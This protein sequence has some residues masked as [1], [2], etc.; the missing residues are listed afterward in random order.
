MPFKHALYYLPDEEDTFYFLTLIRAL[1]YDHRP[2]NASGNSYGFWGNTVFDDAT[3]V[4]QGRSEKSYFS[5]KDL[6]RD[7]DTVHKSGP[8]L[9]QVLG[10]VINPLYMW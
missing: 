5:I 3:E 9:G 10:Q 2:I 8:S 7:L 1:C 4:V 6:Q